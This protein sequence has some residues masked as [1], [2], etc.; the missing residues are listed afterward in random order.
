MPTTRRYASSDASAPVITGEVGKLT[1]ALYAI[2]VTGYG[3]QTAAG[4]TRPYTATNGAVFR[5]AQGLQYYLNMNDN[6]PGAGGAKEARV[7][8]Y[9]TMS[10]FGTGTNLFPTAAQMA[11]GLFLRKS[12]TADATARAWKC[13]ADEI[14]FLF[15]IQHGDAAGAYHGFLFGDI[16]SLKTTD[17]GRGHISAKSAENSSSTTGDSVGKWFALGGAL[18]TGIYLARDT[19]GSAGAI[20][21]GHVANPMFLTSLSHAAVNPGTL[22]FKNAADNNIYLSPFWVHQAVGGFQFRGRI[23]GLWQFA[24]PDASCADG[25]TITG[26]GSGMA[27]KTF[28]VV[29]SV[30]G[31]TSV[32]VV[33]TS[34]TWETSV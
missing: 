26:T 27:G 8:G 20:A 9:E 31:T 28:E 11:N 17:L 4:W 7:L 29:K 25:D 22:P 13:F 1:D 19:A 16:Y 21:A 5:P 12:A 34:S 2:L 30:V 32:L 33:E 3:A 14:S 24:H 10:A 23:R 18:G 6:G 15:F